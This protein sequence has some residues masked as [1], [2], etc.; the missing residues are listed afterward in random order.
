MNQA[1][2]RDQIEQ[3]TPQEKHQHKQWANWYLGSKLSKRMAKAER[4]I[5]QGITE[6]NINE[7]QNQDRILL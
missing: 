4:Q 6:E 5:E 3:A 7:N 2:L 1:S